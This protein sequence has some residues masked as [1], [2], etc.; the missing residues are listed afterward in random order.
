MR[1]QEPPELLLNATA[2]A[3]VPDEPPLRAPDAAL[4]M[5]TADF[6][7]PAPEADSP[8]VCIFPTNTTH[9]ALDHCSPCRVP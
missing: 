4:R 5:P 1:R 9:D 2:P 8:L 7:S 3:A 6:P